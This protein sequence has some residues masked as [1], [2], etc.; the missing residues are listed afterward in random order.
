MYLY[1]EALLPRIE[2]SHN[3]PNLVSLLSVASSII[4][5]FP[6]ICLS[7]I[8]SSAEQEAFFLNVMNDNF[9]AHDYNKDKNVSLSSL[10]K[11]C[12]VISSGVDEDNLAIVIG[13][14]SGKGV[15]AALLAMIIQVIINHT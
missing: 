4:L 15:P 5:I 11:A 3:A 14:A 13:E 2:I 8:R 1:P 9:N 12:P 6:L 10:R 7:N